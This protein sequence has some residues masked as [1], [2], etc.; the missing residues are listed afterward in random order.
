MLRG[1]RATSG[2]QAGGEG[3]GLVVTPRRLSGT[4]LRDRSR[5]R[6]LARAA[7]D[8]VPQRSARQQ[9]GGGKSS[10][11]RIPRAG[12]HV[13]GLDPRRRRVV[14]VGDCPGGEP[15]RPP[16]AS[17][18]PPS[19][20]AR[21]SSLQI[22]NRSPSSE[23]LRARGTAGSRARS[24]RQS[25]PTG[26]PLSYVEA[27]SRYRTGHPVRRLCRAR[28]KMVPEQ[29]LLGRLARPGFRFCM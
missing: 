17:P 4:Q 27:R 18:F 10:D 21:G 9:W 2:V 12:E 5:V 22:R 26:L 20:F 16:P 19:A 7:R 29:A 15:R 13:P 6:G 8:L 1:E 28:R 14:T 25:R 23:A 3:A 24:A 11:G